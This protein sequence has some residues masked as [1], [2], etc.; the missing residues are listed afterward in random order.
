[1]K[2]AFVV[3]TGG[4]FMFMFNISGDLLT[5]FHQSD[6]KVTW[7]I[8]TYPGQTSCKYEQGHSI[9]HEQSANALVDLIYLA[10]YTRRILGRSHYDYENM[11][12]A[13]Y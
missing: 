3:G 8:D 5:W 1:M 10:D 9:W 2:S 11:S 7:A 13:P 4:F 12:V 6:L